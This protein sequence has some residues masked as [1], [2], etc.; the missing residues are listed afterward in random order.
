MGHLNESAGVD[1]IRPDL[2]NPGVTACVLLKEKPAEA[3]YGAELVDRWSSF[4]GCV[5]HTTV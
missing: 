5:T 1:P 3:V 2:G 4:R